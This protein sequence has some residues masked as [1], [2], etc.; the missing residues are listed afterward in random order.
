MAN[1]CAR[2]RREAGLQ[3]STPTNT[4]DGHN[5]V[6]YQ[7]RWTPCRPA[8]QASLCTKVS[9]RGTTTIRR[10]GLIDYGPKAKRTDVSLSVY[11]NHLP[12]K[13]RIPRQVKVNKYENMRIKYT[14][15]YAF[16]C[17]Y[18]VCVVLK[19]SSN[20]TEYPYQIR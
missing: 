12:R 17:S 19:I 4:N 10:R 1:H 8:Q 15:G 20:S 5:R 18:S 14:Y 2:Y 3:I 9:P 6:I 11:P 7:T 16:H 13:T